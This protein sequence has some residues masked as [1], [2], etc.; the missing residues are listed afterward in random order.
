MADLS[1]GEKSFEDTLKEITSLKSFAQ[2][3]SEQTE[4]EPVAEA[5][6]VPAAVVPDLPAPATGDVGLTVQPE[7]V[8]KE[9]P[10]AEAQ[11]RVS[12]DR[13]KKLL[14]KE[15]ALLKREQ[16]LAAREKQAQPQAD[17]LRARF[18]AN[19]LAVLQYLDPELKGRAG[20]L[21]RSLYHLDLGDLAPPEARAQL[22]AQTALGSVEALRAEMEA[23][24]A[25]IMNELTMR[26]EEMARQQY[27]GALQAAA[28][29]IGA[30]APLTLK[31]ATKSP[32]KV[33]QALYGIAQKH[34]RATGGEV[35]TPAQAVSQLEVRL[36][37]FASTLGITDA[38]SAVAAAPAQKA[39]TAPVAP[40]TIRNKDTAVQPTRVPDDDLDDDKLRARAMAAIEKLKRDLAASGEI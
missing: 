15:A 29:T 28:K 18:K 5:A 7:T 24:N 36:K 30:D 26:Q 3:E 10:A 32:E 40:T 14:E 17:D 21:A 6:P 25:K 27:V 37:N 4:G 12:I 31:Y 22:E 9:T 39:V 11:A 13:V 2:T 1:E 8:A 20:Q 23:N 38:P 19:P 35:L 33:V 16:E 34:A